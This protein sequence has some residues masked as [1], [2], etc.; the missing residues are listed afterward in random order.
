M[1]RTGPPD[2]DNLLLT[3]WTGP[4]G[5]VPAFDRMELGALKPA[6]ESS[7]ASQ[8]AEIEVIASNLEPPTF[9]NTIV[10]LE[11]S[12]RALSRVSAYY[13]VWI[14]N[15]S[16]PAFREV[17]GDMAPRLAEFESTLTQNS[18]LFARIQTVYDPGRDLGSDRA[19]PARLRP[20]QQRL[21]QVIL[22]PFRASRGH[23]RTRREAAVCPAIEQRLAALHT[24]FSNNVLADEED[25][26]TYLDSDQIGGLSGAFVQAAALAATSRGDN[27]DE[28]DNNAILAEI[29]GLRHER[30]RLLGYDD[31]ATWRLETRM[32]K[33]PVRRST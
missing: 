28:H 9:D 32:A 29:V 22:R 10:A 30:V 7:M 31:Y 14:S 17:Q 25:P 18:A 26:G 19:A 27:G 4:F 20:D 8:F 12:G 15:V 11:R 6:L 23:P 16:T 3:D 33:T 13:E 21:V 5:G 1:T 24:R 2:S